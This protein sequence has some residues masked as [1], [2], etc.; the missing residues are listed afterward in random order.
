[1]GAVA[2]PLRSPVARARRLRP[3]PAGAPEATVS[4]T[5]CR[6]LPQPSASLGQPA[7]Q[8]HTRWRCQARFSDRSR[9]GGLAGGERLQQRRHRG[10]QVRRRA[11]LAAQR[12]LRVPRAAREQRHPLANSG[13]TCEADRSEGRREGLRKYITDQTCT[14]H[15][16]ISSS[17]AA[18]SGRSSPY[19]GST[20]S[21]FTHNLNGSLNFDSLPGRQ[22][23]SAAVSYP[24]AA[25]LAGSTRP[26]SLAGVS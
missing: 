23:Q 14:A 1:M 3:R 18:S 25:P 16:K 11:S 24:M 7:S 6:R 2:D 17:Q 4:A 21:L 10:L 8:S 19:P 20:P 15:N 22:R 13:P 26:A 5:A 9:Y 12:R